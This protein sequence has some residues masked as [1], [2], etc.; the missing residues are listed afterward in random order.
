MEN[1]TVK[2][3]N[4]TIGVM[5]RHGSGNMTLLVRR[6]FNV[7]VHF[8]MKDGVEHEV[9]QRPLRDVVKFIDYNSKDNERLR[10]H[11]KTMIGTVVEWNTASEGGQEWEAA[12]LLASAKITRPAMKGQPSILEWSYAKPIR[13]LLLNPERY[14]Q[15][16]LIMHTKLKSGASIALFEICARYH[17]SPGGKTMRQPYDW[18]VPVLTGANDKTLPEYKYFKRDVL[19]PAINEVNTHAEFT[20]DLIEHREGQRVAELQFA[21]VAKPAKQGEPSEAPHYDG[22]LLERVIRIGLTQEKAKS[23]CETYSPLDIERAAT[24]VEKRV[25]S[26]NAPPIESKPAYFL[27][28]L[29]QKYREPEPVAKPKQ[30][31]LDLVD[32][33]DAI[34]KL[35]SA[36]ATHQRNEAYGYWRENEAERQKELLA[37]FL[38]TDVTQ[39]IREQIKKTVLDHPMAR[40]A[41]T[42]WLAAKLWGE[43]SEADL[44]DFSLK[45]HAVQPEA[46]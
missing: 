36:Y 42:G 29:K 11:L 3:A 35:R 15:L 30:T 22:A 12:G 44:L 41:F 19:R 33:D 23:V 45:Q 32:P 34:E 43:P 16:S 27:H 20:I 46:A 14:T 7:L 10:R 6:L 39:M 8:A 4:Q 5:P 2:R 9:Y 1:E 28:A 17:N 31:A 26:R 18:W 13:K 37:E 25:A 38:Q 40:A 24:Y 21:V